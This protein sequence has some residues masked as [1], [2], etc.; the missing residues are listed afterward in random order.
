MVL[1]YRPIHKEWVYI[2][3]HGCEM[4][5]GGLNTGKK[6]GGYDTSLRINQSMAILQ[7]MAKDGCMMYYSNIIITNSVVTKTG[8]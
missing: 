2:S 7:S 3:M 1:L 6:Y 5:V 8:R 4:M